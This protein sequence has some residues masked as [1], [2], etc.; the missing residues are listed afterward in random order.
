VH[1]L[2]TQKLHGE[3]HLGR[4]PNKRTARTLDGTFLQEKKKYHLL[5][6][7]KWNDLDRLKRNEGGA[8][9]ISLKTE[10]KV[11]SSERNGIS[12][13]KIVMQ[14]SSFCRNDFVKAAAREIDS[15]CKTEPEGR[16]KKGPTAEKFSVS[17]SDCGTRKEGE[18]SPY[19]G[20]EGEICVTAAG[21]G[22][23]EGEKAAKTNVR[24]ENT[25]PGSRVKKRPKERPGSTNLAIL[26]MTSWPIN[27]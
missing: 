17:G 21:T 22:W 15:S 10:V 6:E 14:E 18:G 5:E 20:L 1:K 26:G 23:V 25:S 12:P 3:Q 13:R 7:K 16:K 27:D 8:S 9:L 19:L 2:K 24:A 11:I 4:I